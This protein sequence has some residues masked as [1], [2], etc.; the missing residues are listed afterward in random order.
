MSVYTST[1]FG[2]RLLAFFFNDATT[3]RHAGGARPMLFER[4]E[5]EQ[6]ARHEAIGLRS[7][8]ARRRGDERVDLRGRDVS[9]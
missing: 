5:L 6:P 4:R 7:S 9:G 3:A 1:T 8:P 2:S